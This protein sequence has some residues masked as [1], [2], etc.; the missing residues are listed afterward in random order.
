MMAVIYTISDPI[1]KCIVYV[2]MSRDF[3]SRKSAHLYSFGSNNPIAKYIYNLKIIGVRPI[4]EIIDECHS[5]NA[6]YFEQY[7]IQQILAWGFSLLN[8]NICRHNTTFERKIKPVSVKFIMQ[9]PN[10]IMYETAKII[11]KQTEFGKMSSY[12][13]RLI[14]ADLKSN[15]IDT[16]KIINS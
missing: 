9:W 1:T 16:D 6:L 3:K 11:A 4:I 7:W 14:L 10:T 2:G 15:G 12:I 8:V 13:Q 5:E